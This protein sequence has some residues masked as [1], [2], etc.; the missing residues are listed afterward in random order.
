MDNLDRRSPS[1]PP[2]KTESPWR[3]TPH[4]SEIGLAYGGI[5]TTCGHWRAVTTLGAP[6]LACQQLRQWRRSQ[7]R[8]RLERWAGVAA[9]V[10]GTAALAL[11]LWR[12]R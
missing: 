5:C 7:L 1:R 3:M 10:V 9:L 6:C 4:T 12:S 2:S 8:W 11:W